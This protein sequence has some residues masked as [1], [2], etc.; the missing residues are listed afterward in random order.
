LGLIIIDEEHEATYKQDNAPRFHTRVLAEERCRLTGAS[1]VLGSATPDVESYYKARRSDYLLCEMPE[2][3]GGRAQAQVRLV[4][5]SREFREGNNSVFSRILQQK[6]HENWQNGNQ[7]LLFLNRRGYESFV[8]CRHCGYVVECPHCSVAMSYHIGDEVLKCHYCEQTIPPPTRC[9]ECGSTAIRFFGAG[10]QKIVEAAQ[11]LLPGARI[12]RLDRDITAE[13]GSYERIYQAM[14]RGE[15]D[16]LVGTQ[17][18]AKG[19]DFPKL[20]LV[21]VIAA[22]LALN[23]PDLRSGERA[24]QLTT[25]VAGRAGRHRSGEVIIQTYQPQSE[26]LNAAAEQDYKQ[27]YK[28]EILQRKLAEYPPFASLIRVV[29]SAATIG[30]ATE[31]GRELAWRIQVA[32]EKLAAEE[33]FAYFGP[34]PCPRAKIKDRYRLQIL[35]K[36]TDLGLIREIVRRAV[37]NIRLPHDSNLAIDVEPINIM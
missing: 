7:S 32:S 21:G 2:R 25:Q 12:A 27:F 6:L 17:M 24:F 18:I 11:K 31:I 35:L 36:S 3:I 10:T 1:L 29:I 9:P 23:M 4:D 37:E 14:L 13:R 16:V 5:M 19:L 15:I 26:I 8:S 28:R 30:E 34:K 22:D 20:T 33:K